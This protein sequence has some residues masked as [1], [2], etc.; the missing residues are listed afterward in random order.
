MQFPR[1]VFRVPGPEQCQGGTYAHKLV[2]DQDEYGEHLADGW[3][4]TLP[5][6]QAPAP[7]IVDTPAALPVELAKLDEVPADDAPPTSEELRAKAIELGI[8]VHHR[9]ND[10][11]VLAAITA[12]LGEV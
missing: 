3:H 10:A 1:F 8:K 11:T 7:V 4:G 2:S 12:K 6:A 5:E 9:A